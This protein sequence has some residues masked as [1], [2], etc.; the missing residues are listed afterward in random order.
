MKKL[1]FTVTFALLVFTGLDKSYS[2]KLTGEDDR[3]II[4][5][6]S[7]ERTETFPERLK[8]I[9]FN[10]GKPAQYKP[11]GEGNDFVLISITEVK[12]RDLKINP[13]EGV[14]IN[15]HVID[16]KGEIYKVSQLNFQIPINITY[17]SKIS[18]YLLLV[19][20]KNATPVQLQYSYQYRE[21]PTESQ[22]IKIGLINIKL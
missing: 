10:T 1:I 21:E 4:T 20:P 13:M 8:E 9:D 17:P 7:I 19:M 15:T 16:D 18:G 14:I 12:K 6:D 22:E 5:V 3:I 2:Q 11:P